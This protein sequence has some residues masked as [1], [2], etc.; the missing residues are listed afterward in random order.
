MCRCEIKPKLGE[1]KSFIYLATANRKIF[2][3]FFCFFVL[4]ILKFR[5]WNMHK[6]QIDSKYFDK[7]GYGIVW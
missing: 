6:Q 4:N 7:L 1:R 2:F 3:R 5:P